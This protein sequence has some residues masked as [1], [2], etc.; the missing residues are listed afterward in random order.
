MTN[1]AK[2]PHPPEKLR[3]GLWEWDIEPLLATE[4]AP[5]PPK[6]APRPLLTRQTII[7]LLIALG[8]A[9]LG[10]LFGPADLAEG[11]YQADITLHQPDGVY[12]GSVQFDLA[13]TGQ[14]A[15]RHA[16][17]AGGNTL[18]IEARPAYAASIGHDITYRI[19]LLTPDGVPLPLEARHASS[20]ITGDGYEQDLPPTGTEGDWLTFKMRQP[21]KA[22]IA[23]ALLLAVATLWLTEVIPL[24]ATAFVVPVVAV[25]AGI[26]TPSSSLQPFF[27]PIVALFFAGFL[28]A[29]ALGRSEV[30]RLLALNVLRRASLKPSLL[31]LTMMAL[32]AFISLWMS[33]TASVALL[34]P[35]ALAVIARMPN[36]GQQASFRKAIILGIAYA[37]SVGGIGSAIGTPANILALDFLRQYGVADLAF[38]DWFAFGLP[39]V[40]IMVPILWAFLWLAFKVKMPAVDETAAR[41]VYEDELR[42]MGRPTTEQVTLIGVFLITVALWMTEEWHGIDTGIVALGATLVLFLT[43][44]LQKEDLGKLNW[45]ALLTFGGGLAIGNVLVTT[46]VSDWIALRLVGLA[47]LPPLLVVFLVAG[48]TLVIGAFISNTACAAM[49]IPL[50]IPLAQILHMDPRLMVAVIAIGSSI[51]FALV[52]GTPPTM[53][54]YSTGYFSVKEI[55]QRG[56][57]LDVIGLLVLSF[58]VIWIWK[59][60]GVVVF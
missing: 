18:I 28:L 23:V 32:A 10:Y 33:N 52:I 20:I 40:L 17:P 12:G 39:V 34:L 35:I 57:L 37:A 60:L 48:L 49:L 26:S 5:P 3:W 30:D 47:G 19:L 16:F 46:G 29:E 7:S 22:R 13:P 11:A 6:R 55:F 8:M 41:K 51:D 45:N 31:M 15:A 44:S 42:A 25:A 36:G 59:L 9:T 54:A 24:S 50:A 43:N 21:Q 2:D 1:A 14:D 56:I 53:M 38:V 58:G 27:S 4:M